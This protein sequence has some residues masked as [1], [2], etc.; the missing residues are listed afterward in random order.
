MSGV[1]PS[2]RLLLSTGDQLDVA[3]ALEEVEKPL[4]NAARSSP[5]TLARL[6]DAVSGESVSVNPTHVVTLTPAP[7]VPGG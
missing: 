4:Q 2:T 6:T 3:G 5:G 1:N 7:E